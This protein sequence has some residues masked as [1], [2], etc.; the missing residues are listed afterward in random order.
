MNKFFTALFAGTLLLPATNIPIANAG[1][2]LAVLPYVGGNGSVNQLIAGSTILA[3]AGTLDSWTATSTIA[4][5]ST[6]GAVSLANTSDNFLDNTW[7]SGNNV[8]Y[9][10]INGVGT[11]SLSQVLSANLANHTVYSLDML[12]GRRGFTPNFV[13]TVELLAGSTVL[14]S[15]SCPNLASNSSSSLNL[16]YLSGAANPLS[17]QALAINLSITNS[18]AGL[19]NEAFFDGLTLTARAADTTGGEIPEPSAA[20]LLGGGLVA[21]AA[22][23]SKRKQLVA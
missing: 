18:V 22:W 6:A 14:D 21:I 1:F 5:N 15:V 4:A 10:Q 19:F 23:R 12:V 20:L 16:T 2:E 9:L 13:C 8:G 11:V 17:G 7:W 3:A